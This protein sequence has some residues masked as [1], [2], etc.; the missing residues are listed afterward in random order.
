MVFEEDVDA[1]LDTA[2]GIDCDS[3][4]VHLAC[5]A[6]IVRHQMFRKAKPINGFPE[7]CQEEY[8]FTSARPCEHDSRVS[9]NQR[10]DGRLN[11]CSTCSCPN[12]EVLQHQAQVDTWHVIS[13]RQAQH[14]TGDPV[15][16][17]IGMLLHTHIRKRTHRQAVTPGFSK[18][19]DLLQLPTQMGKSVC[20]QF[21]REQVVSPPTMRGKVFTTAAIDNIDHNSIQL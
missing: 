15:P 20:Q 7:R 5:A 8:S 2:C 17:Y 6:Q 4:S 18:S 16:I 19:Y 14:C 3:D 11:P 13:Q 12:I 1:A 10:P 21:H 9:Q